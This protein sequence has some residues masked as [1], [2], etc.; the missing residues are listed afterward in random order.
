[1]HIL[2]QISTALT[3]VRVNFETLETELKNRIEA[4][5]T[6]VAQGQ[7]RQFGK[8]QEQAHELEQKAKYD[9]DPQSSRQAKVQAKEVRKEAKAFQKLKPIPGTATVVHYQYEIE[10][11]HLA[12]KLPEEAVLMECQDKWFDEKIKE[13]KRLGKAI[14]IWPGIRVTIK[15]EVR[16]P[17]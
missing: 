7:Q 17:R 10:N 1:V 13:A 8:L 2:S 15:T 4:W 6:E 11:R 16:F 12:A 14:P 3:A 9:S 5:R